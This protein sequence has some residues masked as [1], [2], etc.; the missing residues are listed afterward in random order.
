MTQLKHTLFF[1]IILCLIFL[2]LSYAIS[3]NMEIGFCVVNSAF[4]S[5]NFLFTCFS[6]TFASILVLIATEAYRFYQAK[7]AV[8]QFIFGQL[9]FIY[10]Q[11]QIA[12]TNISN[13][14]SED[15][16]VTENL[17]EYLS[18]SIKQITPSLRSLDYNPIISN[19]QARVIKNIVIRLFSTEIPNLDSFAVN[20]I[21]LPIAINTDKLEALNN[22]KSNS[23]V[24]SSSPNTNKTLRLLNDDISRLKA[25]ILIDLT[26]LNAVCD[27][28]FHW[29]DIEQEISRVSASDSS[30]KEFWARYDKSLNKKG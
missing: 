12:T 8:E 2:G 3:I 24:I 9:A 4:M 27:N 10:G 21:Y 26:E 14:L 19:N 22:G 30:L 17:L 28:R 1:L 25:Q 23:V 18:I 7:R 15:K 16:L 6:G 5:N 11:M 29:N 13:L 20:C